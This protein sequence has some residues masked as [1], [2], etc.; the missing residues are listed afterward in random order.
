VEVFGRGLKDMTPEAGAR[1]GLET[2]LVAMH[3]AGVA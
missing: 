2:S 3:R 1:L